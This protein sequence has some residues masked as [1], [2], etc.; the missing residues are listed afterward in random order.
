ML[1]LL[2][3]LG[4]AAGCTSNNPDFPTSCTP[5][6]R[7]CAAQASPP[8]AQVCGRDQN[9]APGY[10]NEPCPTSTL[11]D[12]GRCVPPPA[13]PTCNSQSDCATG[14]AC[15]PLVTSAD[16]AMVALYC[17][18]AASASAAAGAACN[19]DSDCQSYRCLQ[20]S[21]GRFCLQACATNQNC[22]AGTTC[23]TFEVTITGV[24][25]TL[26]SCSPQ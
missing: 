25:G 1:G 10:I 5:G 24:Q 13:A 21:Q 16:Q 14:Q 9:D 17:V 8:V 12:S 19:Q 26:L 3:M 6:E 2:A 23:R 4:L 18:P 7:Q 20:H 15:V 22:A 11:C